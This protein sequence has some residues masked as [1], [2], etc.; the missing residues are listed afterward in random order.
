M[1]VFSHERFCYYALFPF[2]RAFIATFHS[3]CGGHHG[4]LIGVAVLPLAAAYPP[5]AIS[6]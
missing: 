3:L 2:F 5:L 6:A 4:R 1:N